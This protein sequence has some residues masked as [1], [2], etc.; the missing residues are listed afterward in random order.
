MDVL[1][2]IKNKQ[3]N[4]K[5]TNKHTNQKEKKKKKTQLSKPVKIN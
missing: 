3:T 5:L 2:G 4:E 1:T